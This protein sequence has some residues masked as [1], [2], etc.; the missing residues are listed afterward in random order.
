[1]NFLSPAFFLFFP[2]VMLCFFLLPQRA[3]PWCLLAA[4]A[5]FCLWAGVECLLFLLCAALVTYAGARLLENRAQ[6]GRRAVL[7]LA[8]LL[9]F[10]TLFLFKY[11]SFTLSLTQRLLA[12]TG[13]PCSIASPELI[14]PVGISFY[15][16]MAAGYLIDVYRGDRAAQRSF[17]LLVLFLSFFPHLV[18]G[19][20]DR[21]GLMDLLRTPPA[22]DYDR[23]RAG[24]L[25]FL[26]GAF[27]KLCIA[28]RLAILVN[29][30]FAA[31]EQ[32][33]ALQVFAA[34]CAFSV[35]IYCDFS[36]YSDMALGV[37]GAM[38]IPLMENFRT[39]YFSRSI[40]EFWRRWHISLSSWFRDY[41]Y[42]PLGG[43]RR[44]SGRKYCNILI[45][46][47]VSGLWHGAGLTFLVWGLLNG[48]YQAAGG[49]TAG[50][51]S[52]CRQALGLR[53]DSPVT[54]WWQMLVTFLLSTLAWVFFKAASL[55]SALAVLRGM[56]SGPLLVRPILANTGLDRGECLVA[57]LCLAALL[58][59]DLLSLRRRVCE[60]FLTL[61]RPLRWVLV[62]ALL[63]TVAVF[64]VYGTGYDAQD[65]IYFKF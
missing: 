11:L 17:P 56:V 26:W 6:R 24:L 59:V 40:G 21:S 61:P 13:R 10:G 34:A 52:R 51:R 30:V 53:D 41:L 2:A 44:G 54:R 38:G 64:G 46:F 28:D 49:L 3:Q 5:L 37:A 27:K 39:P 36:A 22:F 63:L 62:L 18:S 19:P 16:F 15:L 55:S 8:L 31:P 32:F 35:Q 50:L 65:F 43:S 45:V 23:F 4:S 42:I 47:A 33:G 58:A 1:M 29:A 48:A 12:L 7:I 9:L 14:L 60:R 57:L 20:I 25:R